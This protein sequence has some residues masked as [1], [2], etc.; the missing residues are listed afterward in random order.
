MLLQPLIENAI[1]YAIAISE[2]GGTISVAGTIEDGKLCLRIADTGPGVAA[3]Q[4][5]K[6]SSGVGLANTRERLTVLYGHH[7]SLTFENLKPSGLL[8]RICIP[9]EDSRTDHA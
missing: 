3:L 7:H 8:V 5:S 9:F 4:G 2:N 6:S 1:K